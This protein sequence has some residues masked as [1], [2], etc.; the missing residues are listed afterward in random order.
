ML[1]MFD[2]AIVQMRYVRGAMVQVPS[3]RP[4]GLGPDE[5]MSMV[6]A[7]LVVR[8]AYVTAKNGIDGA[9][10][11]R[12]TS[13]ASLHDGCVDFAAQGRSR[14]RNDETVVQR[15]DRLLVQDQTFQET[16]TRADGIIALWGTL[17]LVGAPPAVFKYGQGNNEV[18]LAQFTALQTAARA[19]DAAIPDVDQLFQQREGAL[20][21]SQKALE[22]FV[23]AAVATGRSRYEPG[24]MERE[25]IDAIPGSL[26]AHP[27]G[28]AVIT[29]LSSPDNASVLVKFTAPGGTSFDVFSRVAPE[30]EWTLSGDDVIERELSI[31]RLVSGP[32]TYEVKV[33]PR[34][35][36]GPG[37]ESEVGSF[38]FA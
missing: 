29:D 36:R 31:P 19:A 33:L 35:S 12:R 14:Y 15:F 17:P 8:S 6:A 16:M 11:L 9:R 32:V 20:H 23:G 24:T 1:V 13:I 7:A 21:T 27:P 34:N 25:V 3:F 18:T 10:A 26:P 22:D 4:D 28:Q 37:P 2:F 30:E 38:S 5:V